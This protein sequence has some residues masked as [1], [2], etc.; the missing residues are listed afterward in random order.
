[1]KDLSLECALR[2]DKLIAKV[3]HPF[4][5]EDVNVSRHRP[6]FCICAQLCVHISVV[7]GKSKSVLMRA[8][9]IQMWASLSRACSAGRTGGHAV[10][11]PGADPQDRLR[12]A[13][14]VRVIYGCESQSCMVWRAGGELQLQNQSGLFKLVTL[15]AD[16]CTAYSAD[17]CSRM[18]TQPECTGQHGYTAA[19]QWYAPADI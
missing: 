16:M 8:Q 2:H 4:H 7:H 17:N 13:R 19:C 11:V 6:I 15:C 14:S 10:F 12:C 5:A 3:G 9:M 1:M 18:L